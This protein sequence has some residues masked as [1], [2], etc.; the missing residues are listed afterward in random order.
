[1]DDI[2]RRLRRLVAKIPNMSAER[3]SERHTELYLVEPFL[4]ALGYDARN[5]DEVQSQYPIRIGSTE[6]NCDYAIEIGNQVRILVECKKPNV[7]LGDPGQLASYFSQVPTAL[8]GLYTNGLDYRFYA[9]RNQGRVKQMNREPFLVLDLRNFDETAIRVLAKCAK[10]GIEDDS[11]FQQWVDDLRYLSVVRDRLRREMVRPS[12]EFVNLAMDWTDAGDR[13]P[14][15][16]ERF[17][18][19]VTHAA[20]TLLNHAASPTASA[21]RM[22][23]RRV[24]YHDSSGEWVSLTEV[25]VEPKGRNTPRFIRHEE[26]QSALKSW[27]GVIEQVAYWLYQDGLLTPSDC[28]IPDAS[29]RTLHILSLQGRHPDGRPFRRGGREIQDT[30][31]K[32]DTERS[33]REFVQNACMLLERFGWNPSQ[34]ELKMPGPAPSDD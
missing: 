5:P 30:G 13:T 20:A 23:E 28:E 11:G 16:F 6:K 10:S 25:E 3:F 29:R 27:R 8:L 18:H 2:E 22:P 21:P 7:D 19:I 4:E 12:D 1:M 15:S 24:A 34:V 26:K 9:E 31:I 14:Q 32:I 33:G 17:R